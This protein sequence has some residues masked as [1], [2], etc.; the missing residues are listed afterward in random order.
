ML[1]YYINLMIYSCLSFF[2]FHDGEIKVLDLAILCL[3][4]QN[5]H[6]VTTKMTYGFYFVLQGMDHGTSGCQN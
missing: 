2:L 4:L 5:K 1:S 6:Y 3:Y